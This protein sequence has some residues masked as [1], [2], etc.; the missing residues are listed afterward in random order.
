[1]TDLPAYTSNHVPPRP[2]LSVGQAV[3]VRIYGVP[4]SLAGE[5]IATRPVTARIVEADPIW[6]GAVVSRADA[7]IRSALGGGE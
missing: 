4:G 2:R 5:V 7:K 1:M 6:F 3:Q